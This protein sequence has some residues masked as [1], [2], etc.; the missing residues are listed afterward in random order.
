[1]EDMMAASKT[2][3]SQIRAGYTVGYLSSN[4]RADG[5]WRQVDVKVIR[6]DGHQYRVQGRRGYYAPYI[7]PPKPC[8]TESPAGRIMNTV[9]SC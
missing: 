3:L 1:M 4:D 2:I 7:I 9:P 8:T 6:K 5:A